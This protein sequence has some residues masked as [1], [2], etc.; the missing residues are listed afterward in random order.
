[1][2]IESQRHFATSANALRHQIT[3]PKCLGPEMSR[4]RTL[5]SVTFRPS[6]PYNLVQWH[7]MLISAL[8][9]MSTR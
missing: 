9:L 7:I 6:S 1:M 3:G 4:S 2:G 8:E 5:S